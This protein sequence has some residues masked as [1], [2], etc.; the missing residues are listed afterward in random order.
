[1]VEIKY[2]IPNNLVILMGWV[3]MLVLNQLLTKK[4]LKS[5]FN[6]CEIWPFN[7]SGV[8]GIENL[9]RFT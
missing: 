5:S 7:P 3:D 2:L 6:A 9:Q 4:N 8:Y 1:M